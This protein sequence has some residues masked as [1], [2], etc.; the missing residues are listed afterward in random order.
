MKKNSS[1]TNESAKRYAKALMLSSENSSSMIKSFRIDYDKLLS[2]YIESKDFKN[3]IL[4]PLVKKNEKQKILI[5]ILK[6]MK[7]SQE[8]INFFK[9]VAAHGKLFLIEKIYNEFKKSLD[10]KE[11]V[12]EVTIT[13]TSPLE[14]KF[15]E[16]IIKN[17]SKKLNKK[18]RLNKLIDPRL[19]GGIIIKIDSIMI[20]NSIKTK[21]LDYNFNERL[22]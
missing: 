18:I 19:I 9:I 7:L 11:G 20:D 16:N 21:L 5:K 22:G 13:T 3:F 17:L 15:E 14:K 1:N 8:F 2:L 4:T 12:S 6:K 10:E